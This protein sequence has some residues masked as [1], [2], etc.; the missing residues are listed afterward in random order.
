MIRA[1]G[2]LKSTITHIFLLP[3]YY[4]KIMGII[5]YILDDAAQQM[6]LHTVSSFSAYLAKG[7]MWPHGLQLLKVSFGAFPLCGG[8]A[9][10]TCQDPDWPDWLSSAGGHMLGEGEPARLPPVSLSPECG[11]SLGEGGTFLP[12]LT[13]RV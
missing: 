11:S 1:S 5:C 3:F 9:N 10:G 7:S 8:P 12:L 13:D 2:L 4:S 6:A